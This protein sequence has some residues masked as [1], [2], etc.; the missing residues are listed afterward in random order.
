MYFF[1]VL[2]FKFEVLKTNM[3]DPLK[4]LSDALAQIKPHPEVKSKRFI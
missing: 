1:G 3:S 2:Y 4:N